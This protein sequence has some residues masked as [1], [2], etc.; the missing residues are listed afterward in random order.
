[1]P[2]KH[3][4]PPANKGYSTLQTFFC[5]FAQQNRMSSPQASQKFVNSLSNNYLDLEN[6]WH[7]S[8]TQS[9][10]IE[11]ETKKPQPTGSGL[12]TLRQ[13][14]SN[15]PFILNILQINRLE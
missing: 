5:D 13:G 14:E 3:P 11:A 4:K 8:Y 15:K 12:S 2:A 1:M 9:C 6:N 7:V 10:K